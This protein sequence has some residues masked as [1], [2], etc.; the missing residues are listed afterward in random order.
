VIFFYRAKRIGGEEKPST[1]IVELKWLTP[2]E[3]LKL[4]NL[5]DTVVPVMK[6]ARLIS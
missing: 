5:G 4:P 1:D 6:S 3:I 2:Q